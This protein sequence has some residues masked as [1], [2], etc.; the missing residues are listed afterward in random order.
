MVKAVKKQ[1]DLTD[2]L[3]LYP[4]E[5]K[6]FNVNGFKYH[7]VDEG[8]GEPVVMVHGNPTWSFYFRSLIKEFS[9]NYRTIA[10]DHI[11]CGLSE[12]PGTKQYGFKLK[13]RVNDFET[14]MNQLNLK[15]KITLVVHDWGGAI[16]LIYA[17]RNLDKIGRVI[18]TNT[19]CFFPPEG[20]TIPKR[21]KIVRNISTF[22]TPAVLGF[23]LFSVS[24]LYMASEK[25]LSKSVKKGLKAPYNCWNNRL[26]T[27]K[28]VQDIPIDKTDNSY[29]LI[30][31]LDEN[32]FKLSDIPM[33]ICWGGKDFVFDRAY[34][35]EWVNRFP[36]AQASCINYAGHYLLEDAPGE[37]TAAIKDF[38][39]NN[40]I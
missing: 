4:F 22:A 34:Y 3:H 9:K 29:D 35:N 26:A 23:N 21:L 37:V 15:E 38:L 30:K 24:A 1:I 40:P 6:Y 10:V 25:K 20:K 28:F 33:F 32:S 31:F 27:L 17:L 39:S 13:N 19:S 11:G 5:S 2:F 36:H 14:F 16:G 12:K 18:V 7:F 8:C